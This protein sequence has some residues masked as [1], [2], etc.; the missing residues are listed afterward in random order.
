MLISEAATIVFEKA[1]V[2]RTVNLSKPGAYFLVP[3]KISHTTRTIVATSIL[4]LALE[5]GT[6][7]RPVAG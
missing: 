4:F 3:K 5:G 2:E 1:G 6:E 7:H